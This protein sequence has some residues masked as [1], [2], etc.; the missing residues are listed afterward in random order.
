LQYRVTTGGRV[1]NAF[2]AISSGDSDFDAMA[3]QCISN[4][5]Y[6]PGTMGGKPTDRPWGAA[7]GWVPHAGLVDFEGSGKWHICGDEFYPAAEK[8]AKTEGAT[9]ISFHIVP[10]GTVQDVHVELSSG[11]TSLDQAAMACAAQ[12]KY[13]GLPFGVDKPDLKQVATVF[14]RGAHVFVLEFNGIRC[15]NGISTQ[16]CKK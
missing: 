6:Q 12:W 9:N 13:R 2:V 14:W 7:I 11:N 3:L 1:E 4:L 5:Q 15:L 10:P 8:A 16:F